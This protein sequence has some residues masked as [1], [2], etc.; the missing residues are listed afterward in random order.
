MSEWFKENKIPLAHAVIVLCILGSATVTVMAVGDF[1]NMDLRGVL[2]LLVLTCCLLIAKNVFDNSREAIA[3]EKLNESLKENDSFT[4]KALY[5][6]LYRNS[7]VPYLVIDH[8]GHVHSANMAACRMLGVSQQEVLS[9]QVFEVIRCESIDHIDLLQERFRN[10]IAFS[11]EKVQILRDDHEECWAMMSLF[12]ISHVRGNNIG[13]LTLVD[14][15][16][17]KKIEDAKTQFVSLASHQLRTP[18]AG[19]KWSAELLQMDSPD[20]FTDRQRKYIDRLLLSVRR[21]SVL[22][23]DFLRVSRFELGTFV[24][25]LTNF[26]VK[27]LFEDVVLEQAARVDQKEL[28]VKTFYDDALT[29]IQSDKNLLRMIV[30]NLLSN[31]V[32]YTKEKGTIHLGYKKNLDSIVISVVDNGMG[33]PA[34]DQQRIFSKLFRARN[35]V[36]DV[37]DGTGLGLYIVKEAVDVLKGNITFTSVENQGTTFE[38]VLPID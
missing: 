28:K 31:A 25:E 4:S 7:P 38:V 8:T 12:P 14:I 27:E 32:K 11:D 16:K 17:Q 15:T 9:V 29:V 5:L 3:L 23:D 35:A 13:L 19:M 36:R 6:E 30:T 33:I 24:P 10:G 2:G 20:N 22:V 34:N 37:P 26:N 1:S 18:I 21:M